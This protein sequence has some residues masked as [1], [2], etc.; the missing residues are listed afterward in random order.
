MFGE[1]LRKTHVIL[2]AALIVKPHLFSLNWNVF[3]KIKLRCILLASTTKFRI[4]HH[5]FVRDLACFNH[6]RSVL[7][8]CCSC[9]GHI[10][11][12]FCCEL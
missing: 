5:C 6:L 2:F 8:T 12:P 4:L 10:F 3:N 11:F 9:V 7:P 1:V